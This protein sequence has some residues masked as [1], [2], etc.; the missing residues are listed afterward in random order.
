[1][2]EVEAIK[3]INDAYETF[4]ALYTKPDF[5]MAMALSIK[6]LENQEKIKEALTHYNLDD[7]DV[8]G[9]LTDFKGFYKEVKNIIYGDDKE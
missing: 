4:F 7:G 9:V 8:I 2:T 6:A 1:M 3:T 5:D